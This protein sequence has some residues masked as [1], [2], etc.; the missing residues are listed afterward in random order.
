MVYFLPKRL[1][2][3]APR[4]TPGR[5]RVPSRSC[6]SAVER[7]L[8]DLLTTDEIISPENVPFGN[9]TK[10]YLSFDCQHGTYIDSV[11]C[12]CLQEPCS[13]SADERLPVVAKYKAVGYSALDRSSAI[14]LAVQHLHPK[15]VKNLAQL[16]GLL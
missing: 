5:E 1:H 12:T 15:L 16:L 7:M 2:K 4:K 10:S 14:K 3:S 6:H 9:V 13:T 8:F 11:M